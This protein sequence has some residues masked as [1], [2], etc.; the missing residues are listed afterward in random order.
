[1]Y[2]VRSFPFWGAGRIVLALLFPFVFTVLNAQSTARQIAPAYPLITHDSYFSIWS[3]SDQLNQSTTVHWTGQQQSMIG[4]IEVDDRF[5]RFLGK[6]PDVYHEILPTTNDKSYQAKYSF[7]Q[8]AKDW[9]TLS[10]NDSKWQEGAAPFGDNEHTAQTLWNTKDLWVRRDFEMDPASLNQSPVLLNI[11]HDD[12]V[13]VYLN[14]KEIWKKQGWTDKYLKLKTAVNLKAL[15]KKGKNV[16]A[17]HVANTAGGAFLDAGL[18]QLQQQKELDQI[19]TA[20]Q[21]G[22]EVKATQTNYQF[23]AGDVA[24]NVQFISPLLLDRMDILSRPVSYIDYH[25]SSLDGKAHQVKLYLCVSS[26]LAVDQPREQVAAFRKND[27]GLSYLQT[28]TTSQPILKKKG[29]N[30]RIDWG[31]FY[32]GGTGN[33]ALKQYLSE[34]A[35][36]GIKAFVSGK[37]YNTATTMQGK[38]LGLN[39]VQ[40][41][42]RVEGAASAYIEL[43]YDERYAVQYFHENLRPWWNKDGKQTIQGQ[44]LVAAK[45]HDQVLALCKSLDQQIKDNGLKYGGEKYAHLLNLAYRQSIAAHAIVESPQGELLFLSKENFSNGSINT[46]DI[47]YPSSALYLLHNPDLLKGMMNGI[48]YY[49]ESGKWNKPFPAH[50]LGTYPI[51][52]GQTYGEDMPVEEGG[53][54]VILAAAIAAVEGNANYAKSHWKTLTTWTDYLASQGMDPANQLCTDDFAGH[55][56]RNANLSIKAIEAVGAYGKMAEMLGD[57]QTAQKYSAMARQMAAKWQQLADAGDHYTLTFQGI[58]DSWSQKYNMVWDKMLGINAFPGS[59]AAKELTFYKTKQLAFGLP[60]DSRKTY[61]KSDWIMWTASMT[62]SRKDFE[63]FIDPIYKFATQTPDR[64]P[65]SDWHETTNGHQVGFQ[66]RSVVGGY[67]MRVL[68]QKLINK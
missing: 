24:L 56:A 16:L 21:T 7:E 6:S 44:L 36:A 22:V 27:N 50:D 35:D 67:F 65:L 54:M 59:V 2:Q 28:G 10:Y 14:G 32:V 13:E 18:V 8:P 33:G 66:A 45:D 31:Y 51:A 49:S 48:F 34:N 19:T 1:M 52:N 57:K 39:T 11:C 60:L 38:S 40:D 25:V 62:G 43:A 3:N 17:I 68:E 58:K 4:I 55:L 29:D 64:V 42:G 53:N 12:N 46:V 9:T 5:Y 61:T 63:T 37:P 47:T 30:V 26:D 41:L 20:E 15:L 23:K